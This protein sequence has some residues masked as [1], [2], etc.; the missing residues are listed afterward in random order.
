[1]R[2]I[3]GAMSAVRPL[4]GRAILIGSLLACAACDTD[5]SPHWQE[6]I[7]ELMDA[8]ARP[9]PPPEDAA[10]PDAA[11]PAPGPDAGAQTSGFDCMV[12]F[13]CDQADPGCPPLCLVLSMAIDQCAPG[14]ECRSS[15]YTPVPCRLCKS[16]PIR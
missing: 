1:M 2:G 15:G 6:Q 12:R 16:E 14:E 9:E 8:G 5:F 13:R 7:D 4:L 11:L 10:Q 3:V